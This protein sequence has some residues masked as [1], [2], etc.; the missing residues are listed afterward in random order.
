MVSITLR[1][2]R[3]GGS[4]GLRGVNVVAGNARGVK[5]LDT[6]EVIVGYEGSRLCS[7]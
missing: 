1:S 5:R 3:S 2:Q 4:A 7:R 6:G